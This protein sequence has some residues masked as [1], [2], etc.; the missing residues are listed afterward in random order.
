MNH[1]I[2]NIFISS[3]L[4]LVFTTFNVGIPIVTYLCPMMSVENPHCEIRPPVTHDVLS[5]TSNIPDC[6][7]SHIIAERN[8]IPYLSIEQF[9]ISHQLPLDQFAHAAKDTYLVLGQTVLTEGS[10]ISASPHFRETV[11]LSILNST[12]LI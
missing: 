4:I 5:I 10:C 1:R 7:S 6:C 11:S 9:K 3:G 2:L 8:T 12:L